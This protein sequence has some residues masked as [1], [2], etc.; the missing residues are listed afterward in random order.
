MEKQSHTD[1]RKSSMCEEE[2]ESEYTN[3][4][5]SYIRFQYELEFVQ[6]LANPGYLKSK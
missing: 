6:M 1:E 2:G 4:Q 5:E 3:E